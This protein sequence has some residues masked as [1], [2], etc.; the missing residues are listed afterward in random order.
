MIPNLFDR[1]LVRQRRN[2]AA[3]RSPPLDY[4]LRHASGLLAE[5]LRDVRRRFDLALD[6]GCHPDEIDAC[7]GSAGRIGGLVVMDPSE[8]VVRGRGG[9]G[10]VADE[11][12]LPLAA[13]SVDL[14]LACATLH[15]VN[16]LPGTLLQLRHVLKPDGLLLAALPGAGTL[17]ELREVLLEAEIAERGG[18][19]LRIAPFT[20][21]RDAGALLQR[22]GY[23]LPVVDVETVTVTYDHP[24][25]LLA[26]LRA[27]GQASAL[28][29]RD[30][31]PLS[32]D[33]LVRAMDLY[34]R[35]FAAPSGRVPASFQ[36]LMLAGWAPDPSQPQPRPRGSARLGLARELDPKSSD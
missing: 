22:A 34:Q 24:L 14:V 6:I 11:E 12:A 9:M 31:R 28:S 3:L 19:A 16:D 17:A 13:A 26:E 35:R 29:E 20:D 1:R 8:A 33:V 5:R 27:M 10:L 30:P 2:R 18:A 25:K 7:L 32:R 21:V 4:L 15:W 23:A 36:F